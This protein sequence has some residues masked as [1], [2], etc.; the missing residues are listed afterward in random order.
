MAKK[1]GLG[2][3]A[4]LA[5]LG[6]LLYNIAYAKQVGMAGDQRGSGPLWK[7]QVSKTVQMK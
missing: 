3:V 7:P 1:R 4:A 6:N 2:S 5:A